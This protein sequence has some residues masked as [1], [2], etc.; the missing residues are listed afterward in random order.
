MSKYIKLPNG[1]SM[2]CYSFSQNAGNENDYIIRFIN[3]KDIPDSESKITVEDVRNFLGDQIIDFITYIQDDGDNTL[4]TTY[5]IY[6]KRS[7]VYI[8]D[9]TISE[10]TNQQ[11]DD[12]ESI[13]V[14]HDIEV[15]LIT[16]IL[17]K[18]DT[19]EEINNLK[20][21]I[22]VVNTN[23]LTLEE[24]K[25]YQKDLVGKECDKAI[26]SGSDVET[27]LGTKHFSYT[28]ED[29][30]NISELINTILV[31]NFSVSVPYH[32]DG[33][34]CTIYTA[35]DMILIYAKLSAN[36]LYHTTYCNFL[37][38]MIQDATEIEELK[39]ITYGIEIAEKYSEAMSDVLNQG[40][41]MME[42]MT[43]S[44]TS[45]TV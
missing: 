21:I 15:E 39:N 18:P 45:R 12:G 4:N 38:M 30:N 16:A 36:K 26:Y 31:T 20:S 2:E 14:P 10:Y 42:A 23:N 11:M 40:N 8:E 17:K 33:E 32:A 29:Q 27:S 7:M 28:L 9:S 25:T 43:A 34:S 41:I 5:D 1:K 37:N 22:G 44:I 35:Q 6:A 3:R 13:S 19:E 24:Y